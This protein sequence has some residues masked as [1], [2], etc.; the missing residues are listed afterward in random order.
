MCIATNVGGCSIT[1]KEI[2]WSIDTGKTKESRF[3]VKTGVQ[4]LAT[5]SV[6]QEQSDQRMG[7][8]GRTGDGFGFQVMNDEES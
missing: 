1:I 3:D 7:R 5:V 4:S 8:S 2:F 6:S